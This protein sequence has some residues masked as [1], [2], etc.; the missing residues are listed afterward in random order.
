MKKPTIRT[1]AAPAGKVLSRDGPPA[2]PSYAT[3]SDRW[4]TAV[5]T[6]REP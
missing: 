1:A 6:V 3:W 5:A 2:T 4:P